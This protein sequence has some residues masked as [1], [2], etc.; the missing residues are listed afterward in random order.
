MANSIKLGAINGL[1]GFV[2]TGID[3]FSEGASVSEAG[4]INNDGFDDII[5]GSR[6]PGALAGESY[7]LFGKRSGFSRNF[8]VSSLNGSNGFVL[9]GVDSQDG[10]GFSVSSAGDIN[11]D[12]IDDLIIGAPRANPTD[13]GAFNGSGQS[14]VVFGR[15]S[16]F[17]SIFNLADLLPGNGGNGSNGFA[18]N[19]EEFADRSGTS[20]SSAGDFNGDGNS[21]LI[22]GAPANTATNGR[23]DAGESYVI[24]G[25]QTP[26]SSPVELSSLNGSDGFSLNGEFDRDESGI[27]VSSAGDL[28][29]DGFDDII[30]GAPRSDINGKS[31]VGKSYVVFGRSTGFPSELSN[32]NGL[33]GFTINGIKSEDDLGRQVSNIGDVNGDGID[34]I[35]INAPVG[36]IQQNGGSSYVIF[37]SKGRFRPSVNVKQLNGRNGFLITGDR[38]GIKSVSGAGDFNGDGIEDLI[39]GAPNA[40]SNNESKAGESYIVY[41]R[42]D[43]TFPTV[44]LAS[45]SSREGFV[46]KG[47]ER[48][49]NAGQNVSGVGDINQDGFDDVIIDAD[50]GSYVVFGRASIQAG[51][52]VVPGSSN[53]ADNLGG[54]AGKDLLRGLGG[55]DSLVG[56]SGNDEI[57]G[58]LGNDTLRGGAGNDF[59]SGC[60]GQ[61]R[62][63]GDDGNDRLS[64]GIGNDR[65]KGGNGKD[66]L[67]GDDDKDTLSGGSGNDTLIG[68]NGKDIL[69][70]NVGR[71]IFDFNNVRESRVGAAKRDIITDFRRNQ[72]KIDLRTI[73]AKTGKGNQAFRFIGRA[74]FSGRKGE[75]RYTLGRN[76]TVVSG[77]INGDKVNDFQIQ[78][79]KAINLS[80]N[81]FLL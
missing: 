69:T 58:N 24:F 10:S 18:I 55:N 40:D 79:S 8:D 60:R 63:F 27:S 67:F 54:T 17:P 9:K 12:N 41:G 16:N 11:G 42:C 44:D 49:D 80:S 22:I 74:K 39:V 77:D 64:G 68:G 76:S 78:L 20:V 15:N 32:L 45:L 46:I 36:S 57:F 30:I 38:R 71:D 3:K 35:I 28:N 13:N 33:N 48:G 70:G 5:I 14:Y 53:R 52:R 31:N 25:G 7:V 2:V 61:D 56:G 47:A 6:K 51:A 50:S 59:I 66:R 75:L 29:K 19:G 65:L 23:E 4:D 26:Y 34:D 37:G 72:D 21:D 43:G 81:D 1:N 62:L 73:D